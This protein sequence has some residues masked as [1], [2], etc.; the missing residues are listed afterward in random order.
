M[1]KIQDTKDRYHFAKLA[2]FNIRLLN[3]FQHESEE[4]V[5]LKIIEDEAQKNDME[6]TPSL[7]HQATF[8]QFSYICLVWLWE[9]AKNAKLHRDLLT[10][11]PNVATMLHLEFPKRT[12][13]S[14]ERKIEDWAEVIRLI[15]NALGHGRV[16]V[17]DTSFIFSDQNTYI[18]PP[19]K[20]PTTLTI[21]WEQLAKISESMIHSLTPSLWPTLANIKIQPT[22]KF[23]GLSEC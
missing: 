17:G 10:E 13:F 21:S 16:K 7:L 6:K 9:S 2:L 15:R 12:Q 8:L 18:K 19:E 14:G 20:M 22:Q 5:V 11:F 3:R 23:R 1:S 4:S